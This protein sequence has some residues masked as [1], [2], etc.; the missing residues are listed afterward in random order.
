[1]GRVILVLL[2]LW[3]FVLTYAVDESERT[4]QELRG[5]VEAAEAAVFVLRQKIE[6]VERTADWARERCDAVSR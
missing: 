1:M 6:Q 4:K 5:R 2:I 3:T